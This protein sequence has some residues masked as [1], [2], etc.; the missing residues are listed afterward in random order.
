MKKDTGTNIS[1]CAET[2]HTFNKA[3][4]YNTTETVCQSLCKDRNRTKYGKKYFYE[5]L[6]FLLSLYYSFLVT[7]VPNVNKVK[8]SGKNK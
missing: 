4:A 5:K 1:F 2:I 6:S 7:R 8:Y 3:K